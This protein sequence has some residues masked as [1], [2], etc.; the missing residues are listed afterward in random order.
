MGLVF[1]ARTAPEVFAGACACHT[2]VGNLSVG[3][4]GSC[5]RPT[6][7]KRFDEGGPRVFGSRFNAQ[8]RKDIWLILPV[9][10]A[11]LKD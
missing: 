1:R 7:E 10:Y 4:V 8:S 3:G 5:E 11:C 6:A 2:R 9:A